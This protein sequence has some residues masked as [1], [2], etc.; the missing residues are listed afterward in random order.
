LALQLPCPAE[1]KLDDKC[2]E[3]NVDNLC[4]RCLKGYY[5]DPIPNSAD[6]GYCIGCP[7]KC[8]ECDSKDRCT[9]CREGFVNYPDFC[10]PCELGC[11]A[12][13]LRPSNC[14]ACEANYKLDSNGECY[15]RYSL[16]IILGICVGLLLLFLILCKLMNYILK[17]PGRRRGKNREHHESILGDEYRI[18]PTFITDVTGIGRQTDLDKNDLSLVAETPADGHDDSIHSIKDVIPDQQPS[19]KAKKAA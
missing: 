5:L 4:I 6:G 11:S 13:S 2:H 18:D 15:F 7:D 12:C 10:T 9:L 3:C 16:L 14:L 19:K 17:E 1:L 8:L